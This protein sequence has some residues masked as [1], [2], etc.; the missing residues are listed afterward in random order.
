VTNTPSAQTPR[1]GGTWELDLASHEAVRLSHVL[2]AMPPDWD[3]AASLTGE[4][5]ALTMLMGGLSDQ[6]LAQLRHL[7]EAGV[8]PES[9]RRFLPEAAPDAS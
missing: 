6:Q 9:Y 1:S 3:M 8:L 5:L 7:I 4:D 2:A